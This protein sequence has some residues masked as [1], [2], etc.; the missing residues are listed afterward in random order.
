MVPPAISRSSIGSRRTSRIIRKKVLLSADGSSLAP[1]RAKRAAASVELSPARDVASEDGVMRSCY[2][3][4]LSGVTSVAHGGICAGLTVSSSLCRSRPISVGICRALRAVS[5]LRF[6]WGGRP[7]RLKSKTPR[8]RALRCVRLSVRKWRSKR[9]P[10]TLTQKP[11]SHWYVREN[12]LDGVIH[13]ILF[14]SVPYAIGIIS[15]QRLCGTGCT[16]PN[17]TS[18]RLSCGAET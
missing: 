5:K 8:R 11:P 4:G 14:S 7:G 12:R 13:F 1:S 9:P 18:A 17:P 3:G 16:P 2:Q 6:S 10:K 15:Y